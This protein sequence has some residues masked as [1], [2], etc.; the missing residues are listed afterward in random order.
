MPSA[1]RTILIGTTLT[2]ASDQVVRNGLR[3]ARA[4]GARVHLVHAF[5]APQA[6]TADLPYGAPAGI[7]ELIAGK[8][9]AR[10]GR[11]EAQVARLG[12]RPQELAGYTVRDGAPHFVLAE[13]AGSSP[14]GAGRPSP[15]WRTLC[16]SSRSSRYCS[17]RSGFPTS[18]RSIRRPSKPSTASSPP[19]ARKDSV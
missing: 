8:R 10:L 17:T 14:R 12:I 2:D 16:S 19:A 7:P 5:E 4:A 9:E 15:A 6:R 1:I 3:V 11:L 13:A 18:C